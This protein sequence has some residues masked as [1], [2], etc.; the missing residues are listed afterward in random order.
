VQQLQQLSIRK[1]IKKN[2]SFLPKTYITNL[3]SEIVKQITRAN[4]LLTRKKILGEK[5]LVSKLPNKISKASLNN[6]LSF[7]IN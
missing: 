5:R 1:T 2:N 7:Q 4:K 6:Y 3:S